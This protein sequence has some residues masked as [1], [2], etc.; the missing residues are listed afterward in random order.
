MSLIEI[1]IVI[2]ILV[3]MIGFG[4]VF[5]SDFYKGYIFRAQ[6]KLLVSAL[7]KARSQAFSNL[8]QTSRGVRVENDRYVIFPGSAYDPTNPQNLL[9]PTDG[10][11]TH[12]GLQEIVFAPLTGEISSAGNIVLTFEGRSATVSLN[13]EGRIDW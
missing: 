3:M 10:V 9:I 6:Q 7:Q 13:Q 5:S 2:A 1:I 8:E 12:A 4:A 11:I